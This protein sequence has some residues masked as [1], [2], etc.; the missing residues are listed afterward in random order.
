MDPFLEWWCR[1]LPTCMHLCILWCW[2]IH[3]QVV[4]LASDLN[5]YVEWGFSSLSAS[6]VVLVSLQ[7]EPPL[8]SAHCALAKTIP[9]LLWPQTMH[10]GACLRISG[11]A[12]LVPFSICILIGWACIFCQPCLAWVGLWS[13]CDQQAIQGSCPLLCPIN[14]HLVPIPSATLDPVL[15]VLRLLA[16]EKWSALQKA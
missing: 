6:D 12:A 1:L 8:F 10:V 16:V 4:E 3:W 15:G 13:L 2:E 11:T 9:F 5:S 7:W 14:L